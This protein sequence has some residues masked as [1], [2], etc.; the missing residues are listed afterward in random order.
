MV[1]G[2]VFEPYEGA[3]SEGLKGF[4]PYGLSNILPLRLFVISQ[5]NIKLKLGKFTIANPFGPY[6]E[7]RFCS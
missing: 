1:T 6:E 7:E 4:S 3:G 2:T 5:K